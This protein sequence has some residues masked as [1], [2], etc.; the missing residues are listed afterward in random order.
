MTPQEAQYVNEKEE[1]LNGKDGLRSLQY[2]FNQ[3]FTQ[4]FLIGLE[5]LDDYREAEKKLKTVEMIR[6][7]ENLK[8]AKEGCEE[9]FKS[10]FLSKMKE[11]IENAR[12]EFKNLNKALDSIYYGE[13]SYHFKISFEK[14]K[15]G[16]YRMITSENNQ[17]GFNLWT[18][19]F[20]AEYT[21]EMAELFAKLMTKD[22]KGHK[23]VEE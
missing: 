1:L 14:K 5:G 11:H 4:D 2:Q 7:E 6:Y 9:I 23:I 21:E 17:E 18:S 3:D 8:K 22:D 10:D 20:E 12:L 19:A 15:E 16:R 13:D